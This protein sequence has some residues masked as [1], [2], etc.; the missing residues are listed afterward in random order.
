MTKE[1]ILELAELLERFQE[2]EQMK[3]GSVVDKAITIVMEEAYEIYDQ[4]MDIDKERD[5]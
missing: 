3:E 5:K 4:I 2:L 1:E